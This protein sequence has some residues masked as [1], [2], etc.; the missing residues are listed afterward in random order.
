MSFQSDQ[1]QLP[2]LQEWAQFISPFG[3]GSL[4]GREGKGQGEEGA[5][6]PCLQ[7]GPILGFAAAPPVLPAW[8][9]VGHRQLTAGRAAERCGW[10]DVGG[11]SP[12]PLQTFSPATPV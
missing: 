9:A 7:T 3:C 12:P 5:G 2:P 11:P 4:L 10:N 6:P 1:D 8:A